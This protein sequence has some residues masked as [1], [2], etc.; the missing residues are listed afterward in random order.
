M[1]AIAENVWQ[2]FQKSRVRREELAASSPFFEA[3]SR[4]EQ[5][6]IAVLEQFARMQVNEF[7]RFYGQLQTALDDARRAKSEM[8][9]ANLRL[10]VSIAKKY[11][12]RGV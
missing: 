9:Q 2:Q 6:G 10:V 5:E 3:L 12:N 1:V 11:A 8:I 4:G 7:V